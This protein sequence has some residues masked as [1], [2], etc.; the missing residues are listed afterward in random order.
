M[1]PDKPWAYL[2]YTG[3]LLGLIHAGQ[4]GTH[5]VLKAYGVQNDVHP[6]RQYRVPRS[7]GVTLNSPSDDGGRRLAGPL[8]AHLAPYPPAESVPGLSRIRQDGGQTKVN[9]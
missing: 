7:G 2:D 4:D 1:R 6:V 3:T 9:D 5:V 8:R